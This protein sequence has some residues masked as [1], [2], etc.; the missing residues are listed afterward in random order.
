LDA[1]K[2]VLPVLL[3]MA[4]VPLAAQAAAPVPDVE[5]ALFSFGPPVLVVPAG[6]TVTWHFAESLIGYHTI[7]T[8]PITGLAPAPDCPA[9]G[10]QCGPDAF[11]VRIDGPSLV[12]TLD[13]ATFQ[14]TFA[15]PGTFTYFCIPHYPLGMRGIVVV[16]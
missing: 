9:I 12:P 6:T 10:T 1:A 14:H 15:T 7:T 5:A 2:L 4:A 11:N 16:Q 13:G 8:G 3:A